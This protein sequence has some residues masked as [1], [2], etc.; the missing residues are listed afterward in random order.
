MITH[1]LRCQAVS[2]INEAVVAGARKQQACELLDI[3]VRTYQRWVQEGNVKAD[4]R[5]EADRVTPSHALTE[6][7]TQ[8]VL[9]VLNSQEYASLPPSQA[10]PALADLDTY[11]CSESSMYRILRAHKQQNHRGRSKRP[12]SKPLSTYV[13]AAC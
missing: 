5:S 7:E 6:E 1:E 3:S 4:G 13:A 12:E 10:V 8:H 9:R 2:L 11:H